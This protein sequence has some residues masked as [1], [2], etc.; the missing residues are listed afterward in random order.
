M[1]GLD[2]GVYIFGGGVWGVLGVD[3]TWGGAYRKNTDAEVYEQL[4]TSRLRFSGFPGGVEGRSGGDG[5][6][7]ASESPNVSRD[8]VVEGNVGGGGDHWHRL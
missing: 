1:G 3:D 4:L 7:A 6:L 5:T 2:P 8:I